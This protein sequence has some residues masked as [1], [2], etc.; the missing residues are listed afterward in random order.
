MSDV[1]L[2]NKYVGLKKITGQWDVEEFTQGEKDI[3]VI[4]S[5]IKREEKEAKEEKSKL[6]LQLR[7]SKYDEAEKYELGFYIRYKEINKEN[8]RLY[9]I[10]REDI[11][12]V[13]LNVY[14]KEIEVQSIIIGGTAVV[15]YAYGIIRKTDE[16]YI[17]GAGRGYINSDYI[18]RSFS[19]IEPEKIIKANGKGIFI[20][21][22]NEPISWEMIKD[23]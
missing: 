12:S 10:K 23:I 19:P 14:N 5:I 21:G 15:P 4:L 2:N 8:S 17:I 9:Q 22:F 20:Y 16:G 6:M 13:V 11:F 1:I 7:A 18:K 3:E